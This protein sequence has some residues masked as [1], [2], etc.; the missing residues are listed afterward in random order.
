MNPLMEAEAPAP[1]KDDPAARALLKE[2]HQQ[3][4]KW[5]AGFRGYKAALTV[6]NGGRINKGSIS[7]GPK[8]ETAVT[9]DSDETL[10]EWVRERL[11][12]QAMHL[13][14]KPFEEGDG[15]YAITFG[16]PVESA[17]T[18][19]RG[20]HLILQGGRMASWYRIKDRRHTQ[21]SRTIPGGERR[22]N[23]IERY[24]AAPDG[25]FYASHYVMT[26]FHLD[27]KTLADIES[28]VNEFI[29]FQGVL[30]PLRR[31]VSRVEAGTVETRLIE[32]S[33]HR[34]LV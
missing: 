29:D 22:I 25:R 33:D 21:I 9:L 11:W 19:P 14:N 28:Y 6:N 4:Y 31:T 24:E 12:T 23:T 26:Y 8:W 7:V 2:A 3:L 13:E 1:L 20:A 32:L 15:R 17:S 27:G 34:L 18:H 5:P 10:R 16:E 30:L